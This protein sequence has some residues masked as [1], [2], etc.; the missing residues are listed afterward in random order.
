MTDNKELSL[1]I[2]EGLLN[3]FRY[4]SNDRPHLRHNIPVVWLGQDWVCATNARA[5]ILIKDKKDIPVDLEQR[6]PNVQGILPVQVTPYPLELDRLKSADKHIPV[7]TRFQRQEC[8]AC[9]GRGEFEYHGYTYDCKSCD[10]KGYVELGQK[11]TIQD[12]EYFIEIDGKYIVLERWNELTRVIKALNAKEI[13][14]LRNEEKPALLLFQIDDDVVVA[15][16][17]THREDLIK[18]EKFIKFEIEGK[19]VPNG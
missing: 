8:E 16:A 9:D 11:E 15:L 14:F 12:P 4:P 10:E 5:L 17:K 19:E 2:R 1:P 7:I 18:L 3:F 6:S 13:R